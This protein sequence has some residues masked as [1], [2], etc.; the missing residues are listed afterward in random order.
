MGLELLGLVLDVVDEADEPDEVDDLPTY[1]QAYQAEGWDQQEEDD[2]FGEGYLRA[3][4]GMVFQQSLDQT[5]AS[6][7]TTQL[8]LGIVAR[9]RDYASGPLV[10]IE[11]GMWVD[12][13]SLDDAQALG[14]YGAVRV[15][16][17]WKHVQPY[18]GAASGFLGQW[19]AQA[20]GPNGTY[21]DLQ[22]GTDF[23]IHDVTLGVCSSFGFQ[24]LPQDTGGDSFPE[25]TEDDPLEVTGYR[26]VLSFSVAYNF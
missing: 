7:I 6:G 14:L 13:Y 20:R 1:D 19:G 11:L 22:L 17:P 3:S 21:V 9:P 25:D 18:L 26:Q 10:G 23:R 16:G 24:L 4:T 2:Y 12:N 15:G 5:Q 8:G